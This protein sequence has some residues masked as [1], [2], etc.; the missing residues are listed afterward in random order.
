MTNSVSRRGPDRLPATEMHCFGDDRGVQSCPLKPSSASPASRCAGSEA[1]RS[2]T[3]GPVSS[4]QASCAPVPFT[5]AIS[6][7]VGAG[8]GEFET[9]LRNVRRAAPADVPIWLLQGAGARVPKPSIPAPVR[10]LASASRMVRVGAYCE[11]RI[12]VLQYITLYDNVQRE[13]YNVRLV[14]P[15]TW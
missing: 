4:I 12:H 13:I 2:A 3:I 10:V 15:T 5:Q 7:R 1:F 8:V 6:P 11:C 9:P 14:P